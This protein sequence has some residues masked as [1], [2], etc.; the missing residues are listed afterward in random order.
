MNYIKE[1]I[2][3]LSSE[4][5]P[6]IVDIRREIHK[7]PELAFNEYKT[8]ELICKVLADNN[9]SY[10]DSIAKTGIIALIKGNNYNNNGCIALRADMDA[11]PINEENNVVYKSIVQGVMHACGHDVHIASA[12]GAALILNKLKDNFDGSIKIIFQPAEE[13]L[14]G[15]ALAMINEG[16]LNNPD[17]EYVIGQHV[18]PELECG[19]IGIRSGEFMA[20]ADEIYIT[21]VGKGG[22]A[23]LPNLITD[24]V[25]I[26]S[27]IIVALQNSVHPENNDSVPS[28]LRFGRI[29]GE[30]QTNVVP[31]RVEI[32]GTFRTFDEKWRKEAHIKIKSIAENIA[33]NMSAKCVVNIVKGYP[34]IYN[35]PELASR[36]KNYAENYLGKNNVVDID[37]RM[38]ADDFAYYSN[39]LPSC[40]YRLGTGDLKKGINANLHTTR[41]DVDENSLKIGMGFM[42]WVCINELKNIFVNK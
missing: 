12:I 40:Y 22:H 30:G 14:P 6:Q 26:A 27:Q 37:M 20:S 42:A 28:I 10:V 31:D 33:E 4:L 39:C 24:N 2:I 41:F 8:S 38:T 15:G 19:K 21:V 5:F 18:L 9:I 16:V 11:L 23:A 34:S 32:C 7:N 17:V 25:L 29:I 1:N 13:K 3:K 35:N 36:I